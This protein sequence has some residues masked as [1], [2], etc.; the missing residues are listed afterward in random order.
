MKCNTTEGVRICSQCNNK[1][2]DPNLIRC[3]RCNNI[4]LKKCSECKGC[5]IFKKMG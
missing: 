3:P 5:S 1:I 2:K 4:L